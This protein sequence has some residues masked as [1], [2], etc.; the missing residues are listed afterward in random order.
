MSVGRLGLGVVSKYWGFGPQLAPWSSQLTP[1]YKMNFQNQPFAET[2]RRKRESRIKEGPLPGIGSQN[3]SLAWGGS[4]TFLLD[5]QLCSV[6]YGS[7]VI[8]LWGHQ[9]NPAPA[10]FMAHPHDSSLTPLLHL[11]TWGVFSLRTLERLFSGSA[12][13]HGVRDVAALLWE[14]TIVCC[15]LLE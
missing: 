14:T 5:V 7:P 10:K 11:Y 1:E 4:Q 6:V 8:V 2:R 3:N 13:R 12:S 9:G 15:R